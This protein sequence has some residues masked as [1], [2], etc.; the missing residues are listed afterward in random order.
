MA[1]LTTSLVGT[2]NFFLLQL[3]VHELEQHSGKMIHELAGLIVQEEIS[4]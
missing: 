3:I 2:P 1:G 4:N